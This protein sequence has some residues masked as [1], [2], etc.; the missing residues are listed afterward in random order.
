MLLHVSA[1]QYN[2]RQVA[3]TMKVKTLLDNG[4]IKKPKHVGP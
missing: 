4:Y 2:H 3:I 1:F